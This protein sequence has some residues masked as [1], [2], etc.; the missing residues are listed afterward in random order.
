MNPASI[1]RIDAQHVNPTQA[2]IELGSPAYPGKKELQILAQAAQLTTSELPVTQEG[3]G[4]VLQ[5][6]LPPHGV[7][8]ITLEA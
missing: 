2:W 8:H 4:C 3:D 7:A 1:T 5:F 6:I